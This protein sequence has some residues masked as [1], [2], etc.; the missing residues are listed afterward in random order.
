M[1]TL[2]CRARSLAPASNDQTVSVAFVLC[3][4]FLYLHNCPIRQKSLNMYEHYAH[5]FK[6]ITEAFD[7]RVSRLA[8]STLILTREHNFSSLNFL[9][10]AKSHLQHNTP[11]VYRVIWWLS[12][13]KSHYKTVQ[14]PT[15]KWKARSYT[16]ICS[17]SLQ[18]QHMRKVIF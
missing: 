18:Q 3:C 11:S 4:I 17:N 10:A 6:H 9:I 16:G 12:Q 5:G 7:I 8:V 2:H 1:A 14:N 15:S 13:V